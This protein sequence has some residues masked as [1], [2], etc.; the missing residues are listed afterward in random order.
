MVF[1]Y[2]LVDNV[3][4]TRTPPTF[5]GLSNYIRIISDSHF[6]EA[7]GNT[8]VFSGVSVV[9]HFLIGLTFAMLLNTQLV[10]IIP[11]ALFRVIYILPWVFTAS[12][13]AILWRLLLNPSG[14]VN[15]VLLRLG[16][17]S[18]EIEWLGSR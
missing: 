2:S 16:L 1:L 14:A 17:A 7:L 5:V 6:R 15:Y 11:R 12:V 9:A 10:G 3:I 4:I 8:L 18:T 13:I